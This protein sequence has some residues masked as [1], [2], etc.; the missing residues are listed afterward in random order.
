[1]LNTAV[2]ASHMRYQL[3][4][5]VVPVEKICMRHLSSAGGMVLAY[6]QSYR[7]MIIIT[8]TTTTDAVKKIA[9]TTST[10]KKERQRD[11]A[12]AHTHRDLNHIYKQQTPQTTHSQDSTATGN[13]CCTPG[14]FRG[15]NT[16]LVLAA[17]MSPK[18]SRHEDHSGPKVPRHWTWGW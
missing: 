10:R 13:P 2:I 1:M 15:P 12:R 18:T 8:K 16:N 14:M 5:S 11:A 3:Q 17:G 4:R 7:K 6:T 9:S